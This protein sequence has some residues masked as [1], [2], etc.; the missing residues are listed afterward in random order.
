MKT[1]LAV[2]G[3]DQSYEA[4]HALKFFASAEQLTLLH[5]LNVSNLVSSNMAARVEMGSIGGGSRLS[6]KTESGC[7]I[8]FSPSSQCM[9]VPRRKLFASDLPQK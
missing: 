5:V 4:V 1:L 8:E 6:G 7:S 9:R 2:D 3:S